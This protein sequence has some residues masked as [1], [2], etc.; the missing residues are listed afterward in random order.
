MI[1]IR[2]LLSKSKESSGEYIMQYTVRSGDTLWRI[3]QLVCGDGKKYPEIAEENNILNPD[4]IYVGQVLDIP[5]MVNPTPQRLAEP[6]R[7]QNTA[8]LEG[9]DVSFWQGNIDWGTVKASGLS[10]AIARACYGVSTDTQ[11][12]SNWHNMEL[13][14]I[15]RGAYH[16]F[17]VFENAMDQADKFLH[18]ATARARDLPPVLDIETAFNEG[19]THAQWING[20]RT[21]L[22]Q[23]SNVTGRKPII[24]TSK[25]SWA[26]TANSDEFGD[27]PLWV[28]NWRV[29]R[30]V[31][32][33]GWDTW[34]LW[35]YSDSGSVSGIAGN[36]DLN[37][38]NGAQVDLDQFITLT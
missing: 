5:C 19:A 34:H 22:D 8:F 30:P 31:L 14:G 29:A 9:I 21:W 23:V 26:A 17:R 2:I 15:I 38:F 1:C 28:A 33:L 37:R 18:T 7:A 32:P 35:Q 27:Y 12:Q 10:F 20:I 36:V 6:P 13:C 24:Y 25:A 4:L 3:A 11:F 16:Y